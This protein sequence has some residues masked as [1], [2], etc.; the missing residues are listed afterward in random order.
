MTRSQ[1]W[2]LLARQHFNHK[3]PGP[4]LCLALEWAHKGDSGLGI[5]PEA[6]RNEMQAQIMDAIEPSSVC[7]NDRDHVDMTSED[8]REGR[9]MGCLMFAAMEEA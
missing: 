1:A 9:V 2:L 6:M 7:Y 4:F 3:T 5:I 8:R